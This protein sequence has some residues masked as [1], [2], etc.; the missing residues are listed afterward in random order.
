MI[1][2]SGPAIADFI[3]CAGV[4]LDGHVLDLLAAMLSHEM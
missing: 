2:K 4:V 1:E 3:A